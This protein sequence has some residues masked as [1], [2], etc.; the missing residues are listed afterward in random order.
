MHHSLQGHGS[1]IPLAVSLGAAVGV[2]AALA[3]GAALG[4][5]AF[6]STTRAST[7]RAGTARAS[8]AQAGTAQAGTGS[9]NL[10]A[11]AAT[12]RAATASICVSSSHPALASRLSRGILAA[13]GK[14]TSTVA[15][16][17]DDRENDDRGMMSPTGSGR[18]YG[19][20][21]PAW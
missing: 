6:A 20:T 7:A 11:G 5:A 13:R 9:G 18:A 16:A 21:R 12:R 4:G 3:A 2:L 8:N 15:L 10:F 19:S 1:R 14:R 17:V